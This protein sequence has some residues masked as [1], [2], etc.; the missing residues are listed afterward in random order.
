MSVLESSGPVGRVL[1]ARWGPVPVWA[2]AAGVGVIGG[3]L[4]LRARARRSTPGAPA[5][6]ISGGGVPAHVAVGPGG[7]P[8]P[9]TAPTGNS[10]QPGALDSLQQQLQALVGAN[11]A[12]QAALAS[13][14]ASPSPS[15]AVTSQPA[16]PPSVPAGPRLRDAINGVQVPLLS[17]PNTQTGP[18][19]A[20]L[21][22]WLPGGVI[23]G[24]DT[25][26]T[27]TGAPWSRGNVSSNQYF[28]YGSG[29]IWAPDVTV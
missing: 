3:V 21:L 12:L 11:Q 7:A 10:P 16:S 26:G 14:P 18:G 1:R 27:V 19:G 8:A 15:V 6:L 29:Y 23:Q 22:G 13:A 17:A 24:L 5:P 20:T 9:T 28:R 2:V 25:S 4:I